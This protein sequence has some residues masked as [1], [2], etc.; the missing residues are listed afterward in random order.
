M[1]AVGAWL[2]A[3]A[4]ARE[5]AGRGRVAIAIVAGLLGVAGAGA[6]LGPPPPSVTPLALLNIATAG[7]CVLVG[8][9]LDRR[10]LRAHA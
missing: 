5:A 1:V 10:R 8:V 3:S 6:Y 7:I 9:L 4:T 2:Y